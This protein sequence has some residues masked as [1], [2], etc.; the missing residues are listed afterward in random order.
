M[1]LFF[2]LFVRFRWKCYIVFVNF[3]QNHSSLGSNL[4]HCLCLVAVRLRRRQMKKSEESFFVR[5]TIYLLRTSFTLRRIYV[6]LLNSFVES[7]TCPT[8][9]LPKVFT[10]MDLAASLYRYVLEFNC[11]NLLWLCRLRLLCFSLNPAVK[12][13]GT[14]V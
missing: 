7:V 11:S 10:S 5:N 13:C 9:G 6:F 4:N 2:I 3:L 12:L 8:R 14:A 1:I